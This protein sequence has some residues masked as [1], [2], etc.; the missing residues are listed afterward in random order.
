MLGKF[1]AWLPEHNRR[2]TRILQIGAETAVKQEIQGSPLTLHTVY[3]QHFPWSEATGLDAGWVLTADSGEI[4]GFGELSA[5]EGG[6]YQVT[7]AR[8]RPEYRGRGLY[9]EVLR[10]VRG[11]L[12]PI[13]SDS[14][15]TAGAESVWKKLGA[16]PVLGSRGKRTYYEYNPAEDISWV[17]WAA[18]FGGAFVAAYL[19]REFVQKPIDAARK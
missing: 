4:A 3:A 15:L 8:L 17:T 2:A 10:K 5:E 14:S 12:G 19:I 16:K 1:D 7:Y 6:P 9:A 13:R 18:V 11:L